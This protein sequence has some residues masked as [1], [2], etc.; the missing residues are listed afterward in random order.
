MGVAVV[1]G[2]MSLPTAS[3]SGISEGCPPIECIFAYAAG[4][5]GWW[6]AGLTYLGP[7]P[8]R[9]LRIFFAAGSIIWREAFCKGRRLVSGGNDSAPAVQLQGIPA[10]LL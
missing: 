10:R 5:A 2:A 6:G 7:P 8:R 4:G 3:T 9:R 1:V